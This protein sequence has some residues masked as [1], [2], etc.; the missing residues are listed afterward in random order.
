MAEINN[1]YT[2]RILVSLSK[3]ES[4]ASVNVKGRFANIVNNPGTYPLLTGLQDNAQLE[5]SNE[6]GFRQTYNPN[7][8]VRRD[9]VVY[10]STYIDLLK[11]KEDPRLMK[12]ADPTKDALEANLDA[13]AVIADYNSYAGGDVSAAATENSAKKLDGD[14]SFPNFNNYWNYVGQ[15][16]IFMSYWEQELHIAEGAH[17]GW[18]SIDA[19][20]HYDTGITASMEFY[21][22]EGS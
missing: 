16:G 1:A 18:A 20:T 5:Y 4:D 11:G 10:A 17:R 6:D 15:P 19:K 3:K 8:A 2:L 12:V 22:V 21:S 7:E 14:F 9:A 13:A